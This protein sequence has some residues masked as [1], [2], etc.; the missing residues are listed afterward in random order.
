MQNTTPP[1]VSGGH[2]LD[3]TYGDAMC[4]D[5]VPALRSLCEFLRGPKH[6]VCVYLVRDRSAGGLQAVLKGEFFVGM[7]GHN[8][9]LYKGMYGLPGGKVDPGYPGQCDIG[10]CRLFSAAINEVDEECG[11]VLKRADLKYLYADIGMDGHILHYFTAYIAGLI[12]YPVEAKKGK[13]C[14]EWLLYNTLTLAEKRCFCLIEVQLG[15]EKANL[16]KRRY[17]GVNLPRRDENG[18]HSSIIIFTDS[19]SKFVVNS[20]GLEFLERV[21]D[22]ADESAFPLRAVR[23][24]YAAEAEIILRRGDIRMPQI[25]DKRVI[26]LTIVA[27]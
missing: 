20:L 9:G 22:T 8:V 23:D 15:P 19:I 24:Q 12:P 2:Y 3:M 18:Y 26:E 17:I 5:T 25:I 10:M 11:I 16:I 4:D 14:T 13:I 21:I 27:D 7:R 6:A 1:M